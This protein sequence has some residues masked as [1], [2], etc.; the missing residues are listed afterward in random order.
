LQIGEERADLVVFARKYG[1][2]LEPFLVIET[3]VRAYATPGPSM[4]RAV[5]RA[6][7]YATKLS[8]TLPPFFAVHNGWELMTFGNTSPYL[9][10]AYGSIREE[11]QARKLLLG[12]EEFFYSGKK[13]LLSALS[14]H[15]DPDFLFKRVMPLVA[16]ELSRE[17]AEAE[18]LLK[19]W[20]QSL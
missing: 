11:D 13:E 5:K 10:G 4:A 15:P 3:K 14:K 9:I 18:G 8:A 20:K 17:P 1:R 19:S 16:K 2:S 7:H 6:Q 12:L